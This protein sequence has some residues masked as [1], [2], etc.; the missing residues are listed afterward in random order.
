MSF[1]AT[2]QSL[3]EAIIQ[4]EENRRTRLEQ[5]RHDTKAMMRDWQQSRMDGLEERAELRNRQNGERKQQVNDLLD[6]FR[7]SRE[8]Q[9]CESRQASIAYRQ[10]MSQ[11]VDRMLSEYH[12]Q[13]AARVNDLAKA[14]DI[15]ANRKKK[16]NL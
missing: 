6:G 11:Q 15:F 4:S 12:D 7:K 16:V 14:A 9:Q 3:T 8:R 1:E 5:I 2:M 13:R 10:S